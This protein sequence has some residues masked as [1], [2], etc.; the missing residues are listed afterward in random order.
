VILK[1][2]PRSFIVLKTAWLAIIVPETARRPALTVEAALRPFI[3]LEIAA[4][5]VSARWWPVVRG[6]RIF[7]AA[8]IRA[9]RSGLVASALIVVSLVKSAHTRLEGARA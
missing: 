2:A 7:A 6:A 8:K 4:T 5:L 9:F 1:V 3:A